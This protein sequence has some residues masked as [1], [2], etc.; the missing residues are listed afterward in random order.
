MKKKILF[1]LALLAS[2]GLLYKFSS[3]AASTSKTTS[4]TWSQRTNEEQLE[5]VKTDLIEFHNKLMG[6]MVE[7]DGLILKLNSP[8]VA[9]YSE[10]NKNELNKT[11]KRIQ[12]NISQIKRKIG[13]LQTKRMELEKALRG[14]PTKLQPTTEAEPF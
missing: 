9:Q 14:T 11:I 13:K 6:K 10:E 5:D 8:E 4:K 7:R 1:S 3:Y 12:T 2:A